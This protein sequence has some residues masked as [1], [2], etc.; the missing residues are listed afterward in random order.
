M[1]IY[2]A[3]LRTC[4]E[5]SPL[6]TALSVYFDRERTNTLTRRL[7]WAASRRLHI[8][9]DERITMRFMSARLFLF[10]RLYFHSVNLIW[11]EPH[12]HSHCCN[13]RF[14]NLIQFSFQQMFI[15]K[16]STSSMWK[17][18]TML[19][20]VTVENISTLEVYIW[21]GLEVAS[22]KLNH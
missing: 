16:L 8:I 7:V 12:S 18:S 19:S 20:T 6:S 21:I 11:I 14:I 15:V 2:F 4:K 5:F 13:V 22:V 9:A 1:W 17:E 10:F 3:L